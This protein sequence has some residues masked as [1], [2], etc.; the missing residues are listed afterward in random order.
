MEK[1]KRIRIM[2]DLP[3]KELKGLDKIAERER[4]PRKLQVEKIVI[5]YINNLKQ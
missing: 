5:D 1:K 3:D 2:I 4:R